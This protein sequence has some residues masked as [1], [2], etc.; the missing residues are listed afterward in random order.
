MTLESAALDKV[1]VLL[2]DAAA[3]CEPTMSLKM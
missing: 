2:T 3:K 1:T